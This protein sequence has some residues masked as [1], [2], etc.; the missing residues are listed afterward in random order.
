M[1]R[2][3]IFL[4]CCAMLVSCRPETFTPKPAGYYR[5]EFPKRGYQAFNKSEYPYSFEYPVYAEVVRD[6]SPL[7]RLPENPYWIN[8][9]FPKLGCMIYMSYKQVSAK[10]P[11]SKL[12]EDSHQMSWYHTKKA[13]YIDEY[14]FKNDYNVSGVF[15]KVDGDAASAYQFIATDSVKNFVR[16]ALYFNVTPNAD[17]LLPINQFV[18]KDIEHMLQTMK[19]K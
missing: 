5:V 11:F 16:G 6:S 3:C 13:D 19:W 7:G 17:S 14:T 8:I 10:A 1:F 12:M 9:V 15:Y 18:K 2:F 4:L